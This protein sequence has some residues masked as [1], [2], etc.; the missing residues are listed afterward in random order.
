MKTLAEKHDQSKLSARFA[1]LMGLLM[2]GLVDGLLSMESLRASPVAMS[3]AIA[4]GVMALG[5]LVFLFRDAR[6]YLTPE[7]PEVEPQTGPVWHEARLFTDPW[8]QI[9]AVYCMLVLLTQLAQELIEKPSLHERT[10]WFLFFVVVMSVVMPLNLIQRIRREEAE[11]EEPSDGQP[12]T[13]RAAA[14]A[15]FRDPWFTV[16]AVV[17][18]AVHV[19]RYGVD[20][21]EEDPS[22]LEAIWWLFAPLL[23]MVI[24]VVSASISPRSSRRKKASTAADGESTDTPGDLFSPDA[25]PPQTGTAPLRRPTSGRWV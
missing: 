16:P 21:I 19:A 23:F 6:G 7:T 11:L 10:L 25:E 8:Y 3:Y 22:S 17:L 20:A 5:L 4:V 15:A 13:R 18:G 1:M 9:P 14:A 12:D 2:A 24:S